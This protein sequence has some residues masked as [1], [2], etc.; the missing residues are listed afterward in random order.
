[1]T[2]AI[3]S[4]LYL[5]ACEPITSHGFAL[6]LFGQR[7]RANTLYIANC[8]P[9]GDHAGRIT[10]F[11][12]YEASCPL[13]L[14]KT[15]ELPSAVGDP[16]VDVFLWEQVPIATGV[17]IAIWT[18]LQSIFNEIAGHA[19]LSVLDAAIHAG[20]PERDNLALAARGYVEKRFGS[21]RARH[22]SVALIARNLEVML[23]RSAADDPRALAAKPV[24]DVQRARIEANSN[25]GTVTLSWLDSNQAEQARMLEPML[26]DAT[27]LAAA[28]HVELHCSRP[29]ADSSTEIF[30]RR[31]ERR[32]HDERLD[33]AFTSTPI[34]HRYISTHDDQQPTAI[35]PNPHEFGGGNLMYGPEIL[36]RTLSKAT[37]KDSL[38]NRWQYHSR[39]DHHSKVAC[40]GVIF[41]LLRTTPLLQKHVEKGV[42]YF[43]INHE[44]RDF[45]HDR[46]KNL[47][48]VLCTPSSVGAAQPPVTLSS[49]A[50]EY[51]IDL[52]A[53]EQSELVA[54][55]VLL[56]APVGSVL[57]ALEAKACM[58][59]HQRALPRLYDELNSSHLTIHGATDQAIAAGFTMVNISDHYL[60]P[61]M[62]K[63]NRIS[64]PKWS[65]HQQ[66][67]D[68]Q[69]AIDKIRQLPKRSRTGDTGYDALSIVIVN[70]ANDGS[71]VELVTEAPA[72]QLGDIYHYASMIDRLGH[73][74][75]TRFK[76]L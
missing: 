4:E 33:E 24:S 16:W 7:T 22:W 37:R 45:V 13:W 44:M 68:A 11:E 34:D 50:A 69:L 26:A 29:T 46:K 31:N 72:P 59:A 38:G 25:I 67:R 54:L 60:S 8:H 58:T 41:D 64:D 3:P 76:D 52:T 23:A 12:L 47:D 62:N 30:L 19:P 57:M 10:E 39:S 40:W 15:L 32:F 21:K 49:I 51:S 65:K 36:V 5:V 18:G 20:R 1:M 61:D 66:P 74:Y 75:A 28:L 17:P 63:S 14:P 53:S 42:V 9:H 71:P 2:N 55:P 43:G 27:R 35:P 56:R 70:C 48:L 73:I 6:P